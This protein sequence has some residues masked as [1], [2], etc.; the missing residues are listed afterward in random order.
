MVHVKDCTFCN[1]VLVIKFKLNTS[2]I[3]IV[4]FFT[5]NDILGQG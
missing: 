1:F 2:G 4:L 3:P 5:F